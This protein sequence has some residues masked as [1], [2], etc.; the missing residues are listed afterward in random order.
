MNLAER[1]GSYVI[2][3]RALLLHSPVDGIG[4]EHA[5]V[6]LVQPAHVAFLVSGFHADEIFL[7]V[8][9]AGGVAISIGRTG[10]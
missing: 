2:D 8:R 3:G 10:W 9:F 5:V 1:Q 4:H 6:G 7:R